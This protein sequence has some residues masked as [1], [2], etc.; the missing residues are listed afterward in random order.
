[1][2]HRRTIVVAIH[3]VLIVASSY[4]ALRLP[5]DGAVPHNARPRAGTKRVLVSL[6]RVM[7]AG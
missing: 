5:F 7:R 3:L 4:L 6:A 2:D 1:M